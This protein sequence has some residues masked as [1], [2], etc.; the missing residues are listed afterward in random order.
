MLPQSILNDCL[1]LFYRE[2][3]NKDPNNSKDLILGIINLDKEST[4]KQPIGMDTNFILELTDLVVEYINYPQNYDESTLLQT[5]EVIYKDR[6]DQFPTIEKAIKADMNKNA[7]NLSIVSLRNRLN[8]FYKENFI[9]QEVNKFNR[10]LNIFTQGKTDLTVTEKA[11]NFINKL[12]GMV[13]TTSSDDPGVID[14]IDMTNENAL[15]AITKR[16]SESNQGVRI[17]KS[18]WK[19]LNKMTQGGFRGREMWTFNALPHNYKSGMLQS[20]FVQ[21]CTL[22]TPEL[23]DPSKKPAIIYISFEDNSDV[24]T[25][26]MFKYLYWKEYNK[27]PTVNEMTPLEMGKYIKEKLTATGYTPITLRVDPGKWTYRDLFNKI[28]TYEASGYEF[29]ACIV[30]YLTKLP[31]TGC[32]SNGP[33]G[34]DVVDLFQKCR[35]FFS[36]KEIC[37]ITAQQLDTRSRELLKGDKGD[38]EFSSSAINKA[39]EFVKEVASKGYTEFTKQT[40]QIVDG[41]IC[42]HIVRD[43]DKSLLTLQR[44]KHRITSIISDH[45]KYQTLTF[46]PKRTSIPENLNEPDDFQNLEDNG[47]SF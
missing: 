47:F 22:N 13:N 46:Q 9:K 1:V 45:D 17:L 16:V 11:I 43:K 5:L 25:E 28:L 29:H 3:L 6:L 27:E 8:T 14:E 32:K 19:E 12:E 36:I 18:G 39:K 24:F 20:L 15:E 34:S 30:D 35:S 41:E 23:K 26:F 31:T 38:L 2:A 21:F 40:D 33:M 37:F 10:E 42:M 44:G 7:L 4:K